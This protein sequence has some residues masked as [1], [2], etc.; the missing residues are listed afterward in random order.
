MALQI[1]LQSEDFGASHVDC[2]DIMGEAAHDLVDCACVLLLT[3]TE[4]S[5]DGEI[6]ENETGDLL[7]K[8]KK[9]H[10]G[11]EGTLREVR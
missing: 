10:A 7:S 6:D 4:A 5:E 1:A 3:A 11:N 9:S 8:E 2:R